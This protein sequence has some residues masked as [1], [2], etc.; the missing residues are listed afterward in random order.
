MKSTRSSRRWTPGRGRRLQPAVA[1]DIPGRL[2][3]GRWTGSRAGPDLGYRQ[4]SR[5][6]EGRDPDLSDEDAANA[7]THQTELT[8]G[9]PCDWFVTTAVSDSSTDRADEVDGPRAVGPG[10]EGE[11]GVTNVP[12]LSTCGEITDKGRAVVSLCRASRVPR[13]RLLQGRRASFVRR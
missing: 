10:R 13:T 2:R 1:S 11:F 5:Q 12:A 4:S 8:L 9:C 3:E 7:A 6:S